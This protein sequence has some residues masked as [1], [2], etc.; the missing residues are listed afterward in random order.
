MSRNTDFDCPN[1]DTITT[2][3][4]VDGEDLELDLAECQLLGC[5]KTLCPACPKAICDGCSLIFCPEHMITL[6]GE[7]YCPKCMSEISET[8]AEIATEAAEVEA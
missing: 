4:P 6:G 8:A 2:D 1:C 7:T 3:V 5:G